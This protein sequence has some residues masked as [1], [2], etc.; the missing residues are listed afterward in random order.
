MKAQGW[1]PKILKLFGMANLAF[2]AIGIIGIVV[3][4]LSIFTVQ[5]R[6]PASPPYVREMFVVMSAVNLAF[7]VT[8]VIAGIGLLRLQTGAVT[9]CNFIFVAEVLYFCGVGLLWGPTGMQRPLAL[10]IGA[11]TGIGNLGIAPQ[12]LTGYPLIALVALNLVR[13][14]LTRQDPAPA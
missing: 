8:L 2:G 9:I 7:L 5:A 10:S 1:L 12:I 6:M 14:R 4:A 3:G 13:R 11:A